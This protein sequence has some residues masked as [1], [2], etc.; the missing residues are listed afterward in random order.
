MVGG[1]PLSRHEQPSSQAEGQ[2]SRAPPEYREVVH[3]DLNVVLARV[4]Q[5]ARVEEVDSDS[6]VEFQDS[7]EALPTRSLADSITVP[8]VPQTTTLETMR[9][10][11]TELVQ[12]HTEQSESGESPQV[13]DSEQG[14][15]VS[16]AANLLEDIRY[17]QNAA[18]DY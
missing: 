10:S 5:G 7:R 6:D 17:F 3:G 16:H 9:P 11:S 8:R 14:A 15:S 13:L 12:H 2:R 18:L 1:H 4:S